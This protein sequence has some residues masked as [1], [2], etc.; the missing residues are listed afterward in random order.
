MMNCFISWRRFQDSMNIMQQVGWLLFT[1]LG[2]IHIGREQNGCRKVLWMWCLGKNRG[3]RMNLKFQK[4]QGA[5]PLWLLNWITAYWS[6]SQCALA[7]RPYPTFI[8]QSHLKWVT[9]LWM[10]V[11][12]SFILLS[13]CLGDC[14]LY[15]CTESGETGLGAPGSILTY[16][17]MRQQH[18]Y[19]A[20][21]ACL[22]NSGLNDS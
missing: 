2:K 18:L 15:Q 21:F 1:S 19:S 7:E 3:G 9:G 10:F 6:N 17:R 8:K 14:F 13:N 20:T 5:K 12:Y 22:N 11:S 16:S 4:R